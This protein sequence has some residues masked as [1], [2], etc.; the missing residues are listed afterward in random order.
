MYLMSITRRLSAVIP[1][2]VS[3]I[4]CS[5]G[6]LFNYGGNIRFMLPIEPREMPSRFEDDLA[7][8]AA[9]LVWGL[10]GACISGVILGLSTKPDASSRP[11]VLAWLPAALIPS[12]AIGMLFSI[13]PSRDF[14]PVETAIYIPL[15]LGISILTLG[16]MTTLRTLRSRTREAAVIRLIVLVTLLIV[17]Y[18]V[19]WPV[20]Y[21]IDPPYRAIAGAPL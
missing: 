15:W 16:I 8:I 13:Y 11:I 3:L 5:S 10:I 4:W 6:V 14:K 18:Y 21:T 7:I 1:T 17:G 19:I 2:A 20:F 9:W 12:A